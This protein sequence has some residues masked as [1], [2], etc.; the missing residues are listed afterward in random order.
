M[1]QGVQM[2]LDGKFDR[3]YI[4]DRAARLY[5]MY[6]VAKEYAYAFKTLND[7]HNGKN[8]WYSPDSHL[9]LQ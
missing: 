6:N 5:D 1:C 4:H 7:V 8:G 3:Q 2:A 9:F